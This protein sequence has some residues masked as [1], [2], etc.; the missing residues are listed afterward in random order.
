MPRAPQVDVPNPS[1]PDETTANAVSGA[2]G[3]I[4]SGLDG[5]AGLW[6]DGNGL[7]RLAVQQGHANDVKGILGDRFKGEVVVV[8]VQRSYRDL[9]ARR[10]S[11]STQIERLAKQGLS[12]MEW[13]PDEEHNTVWI[14]L[15][16]YTEAKAELARKL[17]GQDIVVKPSMTGG[18]PNDLFSIP[19]QAR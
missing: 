19:V 5:F 10:D 6:V 4:T 9:V 14:S 3:D 11:I 8:E 1:S 18:G 2:V 16:G 13:G 15:I 12:L 17:L 7:V